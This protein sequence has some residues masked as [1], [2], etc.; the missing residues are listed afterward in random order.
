MV[1]GIIGAARNGFGMEGVAPDVDPLE[2]S[3]IFESRRQGSSGRPLH[4]LADGYNRRHRCRIA[5][6]QQL[7]GRE[8]R[9][10]HRY[11]GDFR[12]PH[13]RRERHDRSRRQQFLRGHAHVNCRRCPRFGRPAT[14]LCR[15]NPNIIGGP[16][17]PISRADAE[18]DRGHLHQK[19][20]GTF[21]TTSM[22]AAW[23]RPGAS[24][25]PASRYLL[26]RYR[27]WAAAIRQQ[28]CT[29]E[30]TSMAAPHVTG[31]VAIGQADV[32]QR[33]RLGARQPR[34]AHRYGH[35][36]RRHRRRLRL[37]P[38]QHR[39]PGQQPRSRQR[40]RGDDGDDNGALFVNSAFA[41]F[42]A[43]DTLV[44]TLWDRGAQKILQPGRHAAHD[45]VAQAMAPSADP[46]HGARRPGAR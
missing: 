24:P 38:P 3:Q 28:L 43:V 16:P 18:L 22:S 21:D 1:A 19:E 11:T 4:Q 37:G 33:P 27:P 6:L 10:H 23:R 7:L 5:R 31:A 13:C 45:I 40:R 30:G 44:S 26:D 41:R 15:I 46:R 14:T 32:P 42:A 34:P 20:I 25:R 35:R 8:D 17:L 2:S 9:R 12:K 29:D 39:E 36:R